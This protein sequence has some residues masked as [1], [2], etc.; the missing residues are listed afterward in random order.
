M[1]N[2][3]P[4][5]DEHGHQKPVLSGLIVVLGMLVATGMLGVFYLAGTGTMSTGESNTPL[6]P[7]PDS[8]PAYYNSY[9]R[10]KHPPDHRIQSINPGEASNEVLADT[11]SQDWFRYELLH[12]SV[13]QHNE[14]KL[15]TIRLFQLPGTT[16]QRQFYETIRKDDRSDS[17]P[18]PW[19]SRVQDVSVGGLEALF[20][21]RQLI[22]DGKNPLSRISLYLVS[23]NR[24][25]YSL[26]T[27]LMPTNRYQDRSDTIKQIFASLEPRR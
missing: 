8:W 11:I 14:N 21:E 3:L 24:Y 19:T 7:A 5:H 22:R 15:M 17:P 23:H 9:F 13:I 4:V 10:I 12:E 20:V 26:S 1:T 16:N 6:L 27:T 25:F 18:S 2:F